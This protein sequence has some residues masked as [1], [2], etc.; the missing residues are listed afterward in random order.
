MRALLPIIDPTM[1]MTISSAVFGVMFIVLVYRAYRPSAQ[2][3]HDAHSR[4]PFND[5]TAE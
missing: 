4:I 5:T 2:R 3:E 1:W